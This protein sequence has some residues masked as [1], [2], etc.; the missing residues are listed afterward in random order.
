M[1]ANEIVAVVLAASGARALWGTEPCTVPIGGIPSLVRVRRVLENVGI[2]DAWLVAREAPNEADSALWSRVVLGDD[3]TALAGLPRGRP[4]LVLC[5]D[6]PLLTGTTIRTFLDAA[7]SSR[8]ARFVES[9]GAI[10]FFRSSDGAVKA[11]ANALRALDAGSPGPCGDGTWR[12][13]DPDDVRRL[14]SPGDVSTISALARLRKAAA[15]GA[16]GVLIVDAARTYIDDDASIA[17]GTT[18]LPGTHVC[19]DSKIGTGCSIGP[20]S[21]IE[22]SVVED[23]AVVRYSVLE[24]ARV[25]ERSTIGPFAHL[26]RGSDVGPDAR[27]GNFV[28]VKSSRLGAGVKAGHLSYIGDADVGEGT[29]VGAG[30]ITCNYDGETKHR[31]VI[32]DDV[33]VGTHVSLVA[34]VTIGRGAFLAAGSTITDDVPPG[35]LA[36]ARARQVNKEQREATPRE[37][38]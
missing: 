10:A 23:G 36:I 6:L 17:A 38:T 37:E 3:A 5:G 13:A 30:A 12:A 29:N 35:A 24:G 32:G 16:S 4:L 11:I 7:A 34:P 14:H 22:S 31:T 18:V 2:R 28:E 15:L 20:D 26:R 33:F 27:V 19:G 21:W 8:A 25:R 1:N 9:S